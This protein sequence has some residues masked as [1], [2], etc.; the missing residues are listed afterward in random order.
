MTD[1][2]P[3][4]TAV[5]LFFDDIR[6]EQSGKSILI[7]QYSGDLLISP[8]LPPVDRLYVLLIAKWSRNYFPK[9]IAIRI[10]VPGVPSSVQQIPQPSTLGAIDK[11]SS[12]FS[13]CT[14]QISVQLR[15]PPLRVGDLIDVWLQVDGQDFPAG[16]LRVAEAPPTPSVG[17]ETPP[18][19]AATF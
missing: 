19:L 18:R 15:F 16:R 6:I 5:A 14:M 1:E 12:P 2:I 17:A 4:V 11:P 8:M 7:G 3:P 9:H 10:D 13:A